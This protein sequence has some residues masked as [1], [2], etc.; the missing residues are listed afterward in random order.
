MATMALHSKCNPSEITAPIRSLTL[1]IMEVYDNNNAKGYLFFFQKK[2]PT[3]Q[4]SR[5]Q[6][7]SHTIKYHEDHWINNKQ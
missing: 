5:Y 4:N 1:S 6:P 7:N 3:L 2:E